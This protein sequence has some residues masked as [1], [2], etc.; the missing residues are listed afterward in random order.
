MFEYIIGIVKNISSNNIVLEVNNIGY[1]IFTS[2]PF[3]Y[4]LD[5]KYKVYIY[6]YV[7]EDQNILYGFKNKEEKDL[8][9]K[10]LNVS[11]LGPKSALSILAY[12][13]TFD[14]LMAIENGNSNFF[15][16]FPGIGNK[17]SQQIILDLKGKLDINNSNNNPYLNDLEQGLINLGYKQN[18]IRKILP[19]I[20]EKDD[21][22]NMFKEALN[23]L[24]KR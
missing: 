19:L 18:E 3:Y 13:N 1:L 23:L 5:N 6:Q 17:T 4:Q 11:G 22:N 2:N 21:L 12:E 16:Q 14:I 9:L 20:K 10:L 8:F 24:L 15:K 7:R